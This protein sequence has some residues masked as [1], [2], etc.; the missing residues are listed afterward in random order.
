VEAAMDIGRRAVTRTL[1]YLADR[2]GGWRFPMGA[3][4][5][6]GRGR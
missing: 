4:A 1:H 3:K 5:A 6:A 2:F